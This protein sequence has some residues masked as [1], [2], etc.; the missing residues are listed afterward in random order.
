L[1]VGAG[2]GAW[3]LP[4]EPPDGRGPA[5][6]ASADPVEIQPL[7]QP[8]GGGEGVVSHQHSHRLGWSG[9]NGPIARVDNERLRFIPAD[10][11]KTLVEPLGRE[12]DPL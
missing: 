2:T 3:A 7:A 6:A 10:N 5:P 4:V 12:A 8:V 1:N 9:S 11:I